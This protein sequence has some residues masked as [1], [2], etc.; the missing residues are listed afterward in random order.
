MQDQQI[1]EQNLE[2][3]DIE[4]NKPNLETPLITEI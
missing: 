3:I 1:I 2:I 4:E